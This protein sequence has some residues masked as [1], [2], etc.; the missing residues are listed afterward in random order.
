MDQYPDLPEIQVYGFA[1]DAGGLIGLLITLVLPLLVGL[2]SKQSWGTGTKGAILLGLAAVKTVLEAWLMATN[3][4]VAFDFVPIVYTTLINFVIAVAVHF[5]LLRNTPVQRKA[6]NAG[7]TDGPATDY[8][9][10]A[11]P[12]DA[13]PG[14]Q[15][16]GTSNYDE[17]RP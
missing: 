14:Y 10:P 16:P 2:L 1:P 11:S 7:I 9:G 15:Q 6:Q 4:G 3:K 17:G 13:P 8:R 5:G 12:S